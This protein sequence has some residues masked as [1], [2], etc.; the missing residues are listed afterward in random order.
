MYQAVR[1]MERRLEYADKYGGHTVLRAFEE[2]M[3]YPSGSSAARCGR[4][5]DGTYEFVDYS[6]A[7]E[8]APGHLRI[9]FHCKPVHRAT[10]SR[11]TGRRP[12]PPRRARPG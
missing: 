8:G 2:I 5:P 11:W 1:L 6:D 7:D 10:G 3:D 9:K 12:T 4:I